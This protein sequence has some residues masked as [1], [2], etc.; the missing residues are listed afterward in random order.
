MPLKFTDERINDT[1]GPNI[2]E[3]AFRAYAAFAG[4][5]SYNFDDTYAPQVDG[6]TVDE[7]GDVAVVA[8][9]GI[10]NDLNEKWSDGLTGWLNGL[11]PQE[12]DSKPGIWS[13]FGS[14]WDDGQVIWS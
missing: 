10:W 2:I 13:D 6:W 11:G 7:D 8:K 12:P 1:S 4:I 5:H 14:Q 9:T 3:D